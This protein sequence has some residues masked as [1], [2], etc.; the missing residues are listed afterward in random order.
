ML[1]SVFSI[2]SLLFIFEVQLVVQEMLVV[3]QVLDGPSIFFS[4]HVL[5]VCT[6]I[7]NLLSSFGIDLTYLIWSKLFEV[8][9]H[10]SVWGQLGSSSGSVFSHDITHVG[11]SNFMLILVFLIV[12]PV[13]FSLSFFISES[14]IVLLHLFQLVLLLHSH[15]IFKHASHSSEVICL[16][17]VFTSFSPFIIVNPLVLSLLLLDPFLLD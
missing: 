17:G 14:L 5:S 9:W 8:I 10:V 15:F 2:H 16:L 12:F 11:S 7:I 1:V 13:A 6:V 4:V 3:S